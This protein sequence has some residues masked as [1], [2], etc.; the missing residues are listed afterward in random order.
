MNDIDSDFLR[1]MVLPMILAG[2][3]SVS[4][5]ILA[6]IRGRKHVPIAVL[7]IWA[8]T[9]SVDWVTGEPA[10]DYFVESL[11]LNWR[12]AFAISVGIVLTAIAL[13]IW[14]LVENWPLYRA[15]AVTILVS[16]TAGFL[17]GPTY[18]IVLCILRGTC[19]P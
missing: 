10:P 3:V 11:T 5:L 4:M 16:L 18:Y 8:A 13:P 15:V 6:K 2:A 14:Y 12:L 1:L 19:D 9:V 7:L 17:F